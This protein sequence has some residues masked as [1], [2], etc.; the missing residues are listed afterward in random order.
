MIV[1]CLA[2]SKGCK[3]NKPKS[4]SLVVMCHSIGGGRS[5]NATFLCLWLSFSFCMYN[6]NSIT[7]H[8]NPK[9]QTNLSLNCL[10]YTVHPL[11]HVLS[12]DRVEKL[13]QL[14]QQL[15][16][17]FK[18]I[19]MMIDPVTQNVQYSKLH[20]LT[21]LFPVLFPVFALVTFLNF[22]GVVR[23]LFVDFRRVGNVKP[24][25]KPLFDKN[26]CN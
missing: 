25:W 26:I 7:P 20:R 10:L 19:K 17:A 1:S 23:V 18:I 5:I 21:V 24:F 9:I 8:N 13:F 15:W 6:H 22:V 12:G 3:V 4:S 2:I 14:T 16:I 11:L